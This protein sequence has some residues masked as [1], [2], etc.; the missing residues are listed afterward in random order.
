MPKARRKVPGMTGAKE[1][2]RV[3]TLRIRLTPQEYGFA[4]HY[5]AEFCNGTAHDYL[6]MLLRD[7][8]AGR[9]QWEREIKAQIK[10]E[11]EAGSRPPA[12]D[13]ASYPDLDDE[14]PF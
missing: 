10:A 7:A 14:I 12:P 4:E 6:R 3:V 9:M 5:G 11:A 13:D 8:F 1:G 2:K